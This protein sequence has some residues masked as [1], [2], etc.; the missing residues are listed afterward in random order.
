MFAP[1]SHSPRSKIGEH[2]PFLLQQPEAANP[3]VCL[4]VLLVDGKLSASLS[5]SHSLVAR[6]HKLGA[7]TRS[8][9]RGPC[10]RLAQPG[11]ATP[12]V[13]WCFGCCG[14][15]LERP[16]RRLTPVAFCSAGPTSRSGWWLSGRRRGA[17]RRARKR[18]ELVGWTC[19]RC[20][21]LRG[22]ALP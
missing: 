21:L 12:C 4:Q 22:R 10:T 15:S 16:R 17:S 1:G 13:V 14:C 5:P 8:A 6:W 11:A 2:R 7:R 18:E 3:R 19:Y 9:A 20:D